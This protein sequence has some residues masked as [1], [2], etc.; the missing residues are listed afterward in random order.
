MAY[1]KDT[2]V[3]T[4]ASKMEIERILERYGADQF[5]HGWDSEKAVVAFRMRGRQIKFILPMPDRSSEEFW[6][7]PTQRRRRS[8]EAAL[9]AYDQSVRQ[10]WRALAL[11]IKAKLEAVESGIVEFE[12]E[13]L[14]HI[15]LPDGSRVG[16]L[17][18]DQVRVSYETGD[19]P[20]L[21]PAPQ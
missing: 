7:T 19:M 14:A 5:M 20:L 11:V 2:K 12:E 4:S 10:K 8:T 1:A 16:D 6:K 21:L 13:F 17:V 18:V 15:V 9:S 3:S